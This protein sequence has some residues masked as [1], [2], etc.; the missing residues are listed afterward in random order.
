MLWFTTSSKM[1]KELQ[2]KLEKALRDVEND[3]KMKNYSRKCSV[4][5]DLLMWIKMHIKK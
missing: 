1:D 5:L 2:E 3:P 4:L